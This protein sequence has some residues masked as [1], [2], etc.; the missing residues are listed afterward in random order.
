MTALASQTVNVSAQVNNFASPLFL[1]LSGS[2]ALTQT[3]S[4]SFTLNLGVANV[5]S[6]QLQAALG[7][8]NSAAGPADTLAGSFGI[9]APDFTL[10]GFNSFSGIVAGQTLSGFDVSLPTAQRGAFSDLVTLTPLSQNTSGYDGGLG[11]VELTLE[12]QVIPE[13]SEYLLLLSAGIV[14]FFVRRRP[15]TAAT[16]LSARSKHP[17]QGA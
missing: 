14:I 8:E 12:G 2:G 13:P 17:D 1:K 3:G 16:R 11:V 4:N 10:S 9:N 5:G 7:L 15:W 6:A